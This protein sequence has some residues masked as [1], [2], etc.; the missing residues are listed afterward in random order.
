MRTIVYVDGFNLY[1]G[2]LKGT[3]YRWLDIL[4]M[5]R[6]ILSPKNHIVGIKYFTARVLPRPSNPGQ[7]LRQEI[8]LRALKSLG[9]KCVFGRYLSHEV[10][11]R[12][13]DP[14]AA[15]PYVRV[16]KTEEKGSD[17]NIAAHMLLDAFKNEYDC[18]VLI[19]GDSDLKAPVDMVRNDFSKTVGVIN[20]Q[21][22]DCKVLRNAASFYKRIRT[23][24]LA[25]SQLPDHITDANGTFHKPP[26]W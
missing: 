24:D 21:K 22:V 18:A 19:S 3:P 4:A 14:N 16:I 8:Y 12:V 23:S 26:K 5:S 9:A 15:K 17:V 2:A 11:M 20:P 1:Y 6:K 7:P 10:M 13:A 25:A